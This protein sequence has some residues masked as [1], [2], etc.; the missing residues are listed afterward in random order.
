MTKNVWIK[1]RRSENRL[2]RKSPNLFFR[3]GFRSEEKK[4]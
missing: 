4:K 1:S 3:L 2:A